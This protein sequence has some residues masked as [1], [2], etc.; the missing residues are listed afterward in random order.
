M[1]GTKPRNSVI[2]SHNER[3]VGAHDR[4]GHLSCRPAVFIY[5]PNSRATALAAQI[6]RL[7]TY[8]CLRGTASHYIHPFFPRTSLQASSLAHLPFSPQISFRLPRRC[9]PAFR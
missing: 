9:L 7:Q 1:D 6:P 5:K 3:F 4:S 8:D 2:A